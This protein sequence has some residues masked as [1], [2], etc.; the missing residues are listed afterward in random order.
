LKDEE[1]ANAARYFGKEELVLVP[2][3]GAQGGEVTSLA[4]H[5]SA[6][7]LICNVGRGLMFPAG[8][9]STPEQQAEA[10]KQ[11]MEVLNHLRAA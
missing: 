6:N 1:V 7:N 4:N 10:A 8:A 3:I 9:K 11:Y 2:G 5:F